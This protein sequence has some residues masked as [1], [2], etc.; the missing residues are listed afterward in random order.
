MKN[1]SSLAIASVAVLWCGWPFFVRGFQ[2]VRTGWLNMFTLI[3]LGPGAAFLYSVVATVAPGLFPEAMRDD[4]GGHG[5]GDDD[6]DD[7]GGR[8]GRD[9]DDDHD[10][11]RVGDDD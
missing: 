9:G 1:A 6:D 4:H 5:G 3:A 2:S 11:D 10:D 7:H 8:H